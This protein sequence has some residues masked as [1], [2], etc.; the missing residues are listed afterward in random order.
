VE[1]V[2]EVTVV[3]VLVNLPELPVRQILAGVEAGAAVAQA[4]PEVLV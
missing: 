1:P 3:V 2:A 4:V